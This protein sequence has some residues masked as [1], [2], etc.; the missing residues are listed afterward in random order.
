M[1]FALVLYGAAVLAIGVRASRK[2]GESREEFLVAG[3][4]F[5]PLM[6]WAGLS[7][8]VIGGSTTLVLASLVA[9]KGLPG[10][11]LDF[12]GVLGLLA[13]GLFLARKVR[14]SR[15][16]TISEVIGRAYGPAV[17]KIAALLVVLASIVWFALLTQATEAVLTAMTP[18]NPTRVLVGTA[19]LFVAYT[20]LGGQRAVVGTDI[21]QLTLMIVALLGI[22]V[23]LALVSLAKTGWP[24]THLVFPTS[25]VYRWT[26][27]A[28]VLV[29][30]GLPHAVGSDVWS[31]LLSARDERAARTAALGA[32][33]S[34]L[35]FGLGTAT[36]ALAGVALGFRASPALYPQTL[37]ALAGETLAPVLLVALVATMQTSSDSVL[38]SASA[39]TAH[40]LLPGLPPWATRVLV[41]GYGVLGLVVALALRDVVATF[42]LGYTIFAAGLILPTL[43][44]FLPGVTLSRTFAG[45]A[46]AGGGGVALVAALLALSGRPLGPDPVLLGTG[47]NLL[48]MLPGLRTRR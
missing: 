24:V 23:P 32:A 11:W 6:A 4:S 42:R 31:K 7:S 45:L 28:A 5:S 47:A 10:L 2:A 21:V 16:L 3:R 1:I 14:E 46:M 25:A 43:V 48:L 17:R 15:A 30:V 9:Q 33:A 27:V 40:D 34:K 20:T 38:L 19:V 35:V 8:T 41:V 44:A 22:A 29:L 37:V 26:D 39:A 12:A 18:W 13:L 36:I